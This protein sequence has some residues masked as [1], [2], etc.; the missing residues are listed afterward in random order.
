MYGWM[1]LWIIGM[2]SKYCVINI[3]NF[4]P[5]TLM[6]ILL[7]FIPISFFSDLFGFQSCIPKIRDMPKTLR[8]LIFY[9]LAVVSMFVGMSIFRAVTTVSY[10][11]YYF[12]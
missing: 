3:L 6:V 1:F 11:W 10:L 8:K 9:S 5:V 12:P 4:F 7:F 2:Y